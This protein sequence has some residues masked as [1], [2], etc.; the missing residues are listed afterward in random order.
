MLPRLFKLE[1]L[2]PKCICGHHRFFHERHIEVV[3]GEVC[4]FTSERDYGCAPWEELSI[5]DK[6]RVFTPPGGAFSNAPTCYCAGFIECPRTAKRGLVLFISVAAPMPALTLLFEWTKWP[7]ERDWDLVIAVSVA[8]VAM[9]VAAVAGYES[10]FF[11]CAQ[12]VRERYR[13][14][15]GDSP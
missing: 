2:G 12:I 8:S 3:D 5:A 15:D 4:E 1:N 10:G 7:S 13:T 14:R 11:R 9:G 6:G